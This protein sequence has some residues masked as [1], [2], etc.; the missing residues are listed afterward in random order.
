MSETSD[1]ITFL[2]RADLRRRRRERECEEAGGHDFANIVTWKRLG[3][4]L[5]AVIRCAGCD[6][7]RVFTDERA[8]RA[9]IGVGA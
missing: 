5:Y 7:S 2:A 8:A 4:G 3:R 6:T 1:A 9:A